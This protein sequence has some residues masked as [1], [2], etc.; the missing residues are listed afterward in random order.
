MEMFLLNNEHSF[1]KDIGLA[2]TGLAGQNDSSML[3]MKHD[4]YFN[5]E[6]SVDTKIAVIDAKITS[7]FYGVDRENLSMIA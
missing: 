6:S 2:Q 5:G 4:S 3:L 1:V 7:S